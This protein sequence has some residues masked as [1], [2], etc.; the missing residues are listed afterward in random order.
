MMDCIFQFDGQ[1]KALIRKDCDGCRFYKTERQ[2][3]LEQK[4][5]E[6]R[7]ERLKLADGVRAK[8]YGV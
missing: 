5:T 4:S 6:E 7:L 8:Y 3:D 2:L 1:C